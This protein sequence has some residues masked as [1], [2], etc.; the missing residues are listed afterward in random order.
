M[1]P[2]GS[3]GPGISK[4][5]TRARGL[6]NGVRWLDAAAQITLLVQVVELRRLAQ[7]GWMTPCGIN[8]RREECVTAALLRPRFRPLV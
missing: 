3:P 1:Y 7:M 6:R 5:A 2:S 8:P 4:A